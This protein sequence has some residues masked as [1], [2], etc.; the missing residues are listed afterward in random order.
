MICD[1]DTGPRA[2]Y[3]F[4]PQFEKALVPERFGIR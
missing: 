4:N 2:Q 3:E 1:F